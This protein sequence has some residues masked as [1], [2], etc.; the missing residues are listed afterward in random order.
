MIDADSNELAFGLKPM[1]RQYGEIM[2]YFK[3]KQMIVRLTTVIVKHIMRH[4]HQLPEGQR[5]C[6]P[7]RQE[8]DQSIIPLPRLRHRVV[9][10]RRVVE[11]LP[12][13]QY[14]IFTRKKMFL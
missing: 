4:Q 8:L 5:A 11:V 6:S 1:N 2:F 3:C 9:M 10:G 14:R 13:A 7:S 12:A